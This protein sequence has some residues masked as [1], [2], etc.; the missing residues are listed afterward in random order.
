[1]IAPTGAGSE[2]SVQMLLD[3]AGRVAIK[4]ALIILE[5]RVDIEAVERALQ[6]VAVPHSP[7]DEVDLDLVEGEV[8]VARKPLP[9]EVVQ[10]PVLRF[11]L[12]TGSLGHGRV[13]VP[14]Y[15]DVNSPKDIEPESVLGHD[16]NLRK[17]A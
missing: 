6:L 16:R 3:P 4:E 8:I 9:P 7:P 14:S 17:S 12:L 1:M 2:V 10:L 15:A 5:L 13:G 11:D